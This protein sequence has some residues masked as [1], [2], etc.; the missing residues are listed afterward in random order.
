MRRISSK[1]AIIILSVTSLFVF[2]NLPKHPVS[3]DCFIEG[4]KQLPC[5][6]HN[7]VVYF[8]FEFLKKQFDVN[9]K[10]VEGK[11]SD[12]TLLRLDI[13]SNICLLQT[14]V[15]GKGFEYYTSYSKSKRPDFNNYSVYGQ[16]GNFAFYNVERRGRVKCISGQAEVPMSIQWDSIPY[17]YPIQIAQYGL[18]H[19]SR[20]EIG[21]VIFSD[22]NVLH[23]DPQE[24][25]EFRSG[26]VLNPR[27]QISHT[28]EHN[29]SYIVLDKD[30]NND[31]VT[32]N[33]NPDSNLGVLN[34]EWNPKSESSFFK[35]V[36]QGEDGG[37]LTISY[38]IGDDNRCLWQGE[39]NNVS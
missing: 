35:V 8:P 9:G 32:V 23:L 17:F 16:F 11:P 29:T 20:M 7:E 28:T 18:Q 39:N 37:L 21:I 14:T 5:L 22:D 19:Y 1:V 33:L 30:C 6:L 15:L 13:Y 38:V 10:F 31:E 36:V 4:T 2:F 3:I 25:L 26:F 27:S 24:I 12:K 34:F